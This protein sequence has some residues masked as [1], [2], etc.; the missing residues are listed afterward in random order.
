MTRL[1]WIFSHCLTLTA[2]PWWLNCLLAWHSSPSS[3]DWIWLTWDWLCAFFLKNLVERMIYAIKDFPRNSFQSQ[4][5][6]CRYNIIFIKL[7]M[8]TMIRT[9]TMIPVQCIDRRPCQILTQSEMR[10]IYELIKLIVVGI[11]LW[12][13]SLTWSKWSW[14][15][16]KWERDTNCLGK[17]IWIG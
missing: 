6:F 1:I 2:K 10:K 13:I 5:S 8:M 14:H 11:G 4:T 7:L 3:W 15:S 17:E 9:M 12:L 16:L